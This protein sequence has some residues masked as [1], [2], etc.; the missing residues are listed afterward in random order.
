MAK[1]K[2]PFDPK[3]QA[4]EF[5]RRAQELVDAGELNPIEGERALDA[6]VRSSANRKEN[7]SD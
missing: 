2:T 7:E 6:L 1:R 4:A 5:Q 3:A